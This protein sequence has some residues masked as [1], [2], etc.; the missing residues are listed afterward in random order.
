MSTQL[1]PQP[2]PAAIPIRR[3]AEMR[4]DQFEAAL[5]QT[6][7]A[8]IPWGALEWHGPHLPLGLDGLVAEGFAE[9]L[10]AQTGGI[11]LPTFYLPITTLPHPFSI[12]ISAELVGTIWQELLTQ[13]QQTGFTVA[14]LVSGHYAHPH[15]IFLMRAAEAARKQ[16]L[17]VLA[18]PPLSPLG[19][20]TLLDHAAHWET[21]QLLAL[22]PDLV[23]LGRLDDA[24][25]A[26]KA[27][28][29]ATHAVLGDDPRKYATPAAG[30]AAIDRALDEWTRWLSTLLKGEQWAL[31]GEH[32]AARLDAYTQFIKTYYRGDWDSTIAAWWQA[33]LAQI[34]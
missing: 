28:D 26:S 2:K 17:A 29:L 33:R 10:A 24:E 22:R 13:L 5:A 19:D 31:L 6:P 8:I 15:E 11:L 3:Y 18:G 30:N 27:K 32:N 25:A 7:L 34:A 14:A 16:G 23:Q 4:P 20:P 12:Q 1:Q 21:A 9:R